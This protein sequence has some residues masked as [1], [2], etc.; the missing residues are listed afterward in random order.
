MIKTVTI[1]GKSVEIRIS[2]EASNQLRQRDEPLQAEMELYFSCLIRKKV[3][4]NRAINSSNAID[5][6]DGLSVC[7]RPVMTEK[8]RTDYEGEEPPVTDFPITKPDAFIP[9][10]L[11]IDFQS[12]KWVGDFGY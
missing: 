11:Q 5:V 1:N 9:H 2:N 6:I 8:C 3:L 4:F 7:F 10:W 12:G